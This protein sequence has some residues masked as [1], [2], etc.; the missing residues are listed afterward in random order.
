ML[1]LSEEDVVLDVGA[2]IGKYSIL[3]AVFSRVRVIAVEPFEPNFTRLNDNIKA[4]ELS[5]IMVHNVALGAEEIHGTLDYENRHA[6]VSRQTV[7]SASPVDDFGGAA[8]GKDPIMITSFDR[9]LTQ[10]N[11]PK[12]TFVKIDVDGYEGPVVKGMHDF[13]LDHRP[14]GI[15][16]E[17]RH[18]T[19]ESKEI[20]STLNNLGYGVRIGDSPKNTYFDIPP[21]Q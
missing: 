16:I 1:S 4:N 7:T 12:P 5:L 14:R 13:L 10:F 15:M 9:L 18:G 8:K 20:I 17:L 21:K 19:H 3:A 6:G 11:H 2:N